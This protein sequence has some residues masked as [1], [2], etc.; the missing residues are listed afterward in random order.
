MRTV[1]HR[2][3]DDLNARIAALCDC[4]GEAMAR[5]TDALLAPDLQIAEAVIADYSDITCECARLETDAFTI[6]AR[7][8]P[9]AGDLRAVVSSLND[10]ADI[11]R[12]GALATHVARISRRRHPEVAAPSEVAGYFTE[13]GRLAVRISQGTKT[14]VLSRDPDKAAQL[15]TDDEAMDDL[16]RHLF[17]K[18]L[19]HRWAHGTTAAV[20]VTLLSRYYERF[21]DH[22]VDVANRV[23]YRTTGTRQPYPPRMMLGAKH[24]QNPDTTTAIST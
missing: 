5:A 3:L 15:A 9:V 2:Q 4:T 21:A 16:H 18:V 1:F 17:T 8:A 13:M 22:A 12:M 24:N 11:A 10:V 6:L 20:D 14:V 23:I 7:Q 19:D